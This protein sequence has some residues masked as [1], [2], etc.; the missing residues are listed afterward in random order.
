MPS[1]V[2]G[3]DILSPTN[4]ERGI[5]ATIKSTGHEYEILDKYCGNQVYEDISPLAK[6]KP[7]AEA[8]QLQ[9][10][11]S[12]DYEF[13]Q[14]PA[15]ISMATTSIHHNNNKPAETPSTQPAATQD[16][17]AEDNNSD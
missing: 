14:C 17:Q 15:Y 4:E 5:Y 2:P 8:V 7:E 1:E 16:D 13:T 11:P 10:L 12:G 3:N 9:P 6:P